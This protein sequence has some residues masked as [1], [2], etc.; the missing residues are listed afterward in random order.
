MINYILSGDLISTWSFRK[1]RLARLPAFSLQSC[2]IFCSAA[3]IFR[4]SNFYVY[5]ETANFLFYQGPCTY[6]W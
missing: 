4:R 2:C 3:S 6:P 5:R 1:G